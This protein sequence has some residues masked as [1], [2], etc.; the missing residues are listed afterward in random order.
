MDPAEVGA[1]RAGRGAIRG[2]RRPGPRSCSARETGPG[3]T[4][5]RSARVVHEWRLACRRH[6][7]ALPPRHDRH[8]VRH[9][10]PR[11]ARA[12][13]AGGMIGFLHPWVLAGLA[14]AAIPDPAPPAGPPRAADRRVP[15]GPLP[16]H[17]H[18]GA[19]APPQAA[20]P[21]A[22]A[23]PHAADRRPG[24]RRGR[25]HAPAQRRAGPRAQRA[26]ARGGQLAEQRGGGGRDRAAGPAPG[27]GATGA[28]ARHAGR[29]ALAPHRRRTAAPGRPPGT[30]RPGRR[31]CR[32]PP[33]GSISAPRSALAGEV[34]AAEPRPGEIVLLTD[35]QA[36][37]VS[38]GRRSACRSWSAGPDEPP[39]ANVGIGGS[40]PAR[41]RGA[42]TAGGS[43]CPLVGDSGGGTPVS[44]R[45]GTRPARQ[46]LAARRRRGGARD[47]G[48]RERMVDADAELDPDEL[49]LDDR[50][51]A[52]VRVAPVARVDWDAASRYVAAA[53]EVLEANRRIARGGEVTLG[54]LGAG[55]LDRSAAGGSRRPSARSTARSPRAA[56]RGATARRCSSPRSPT[57]GRSSARV[58]VLRRYQLEPAESGRTGVLATAGGAPWLVRTRRRRAAREPARPGVDRPARLGRV[59][60]VH[61]RAAQ[62]AGARRSVAGRRRP[63]RPVPLPDQVTEVRQGERDWRVEGGGTF[64]P[65]EPGRTT[66]WRARHGRR[67][68]ARTSTRAS[69]G[70][71]RPATR[72]R[73]GSGVAP[74]GRAGRRR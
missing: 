32:S 49:R 1:R 46:A 5:T 42:P 20:A 25:A 34:L 43:R 69:R 41:S 39:P 66:S 47:P 4:G 36:T 13:A 40:R 35:L 53:C 45:L 7:I 23:L 64:R 62:P 48:R 2:S 3:P 56:W 68:H 19:P 72:R 63:R 70:S 58:R 10:A 16:H 11:G 50:R 15:G 30:A 71:R 60:A 67:D 12:V 61:G 27:G 44:A 74:A 65:A 29:R 22:P 38:P 73:G 17:H 57:A 28:R 31:R 26:G 54:R 8:A 18:A 33:A 14:A 24:A 37:A 51:V 52:S 6:G 9:R 21:P 59:H 55:Q